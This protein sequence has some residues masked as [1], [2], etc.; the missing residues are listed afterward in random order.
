MIRGAGRGRSSA[1]PL[2]A[3]ADSDAKVLGFCL[4]E[5]AEGQ[6]TVEILG[7]KL[8][9]AF[10][11]IRT[12]QVEPGLQIQADIPVVFFPGVGEQTSEQVAWNA[13]KRGLMY[14]RLP[15]TRCRLR[16]SLWTI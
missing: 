11:G 10:T 6:V 5:L 7:K 2:Q 3:E 1:Q 13:W 14:S 15:C 16:V 12:F 4:V 8:Q 9:G